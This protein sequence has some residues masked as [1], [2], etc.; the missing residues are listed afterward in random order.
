MTMLDEEGISS[1]AYLKE[2]NF[3]LKHLIKIPLSSH[4][5]W[6]NHVLFIK[7]TLAKGV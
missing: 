5:P 2:E 1:Y 6:L 7:P 3:Y 4:W